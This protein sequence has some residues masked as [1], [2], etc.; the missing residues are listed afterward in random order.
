[1]ATLVSTE[2][3]QPYRKM[4]HDNGATLVGE[5]TANFLAAVGTISAGFPYHSDDN[6]G[7]W[8]LLFYSYNPSSPDVTMVYV[9]Q[10]R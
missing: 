5:V 3:L 1:M 8:P 2:S 7:A 4:V 6:I 9:G 10:G